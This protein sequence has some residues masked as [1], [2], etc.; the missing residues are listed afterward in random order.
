L[1]LSMLE[2]LGIRFFGVEIR[3][4]Q[5]IAAARATKEAIHNMKWDHE[6]A[7]SEFENLSNNILSFVQLIVEDEEHAASS[8][9][10]ALKELFQVSG[11]AEYGRFFNAILG[12]ISRRKLLVQM[13]SDFGPVSI[14]QGSLSVRFRNVRKKTEELKVNFRKIWEEA[15]KKSKNIKSSFRQ[16]A[17]WAMT[18]AKTTAIHIGIY[19]VALAIVLFSVW[20]SFAFKATTNLGSLASNIV[21]GLKAAFPILVLVIFIF[22]ALFDLVTSKG[23]LEKGFEAIRRFL[24]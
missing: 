20:H 23:I 24:A 19:G 6:K 16:F 9:A 3:E 21:S 17:H 2:P 5:I 10:E 8:D 4:R 7:D 11:L 12:G 18:G 14:E 22:C 1:N 13:L 15:K